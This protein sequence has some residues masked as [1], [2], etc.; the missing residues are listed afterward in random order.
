MAFEIQN[1]K[2]IPERGKEDLEYDFA[3]NIALL[4]F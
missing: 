4:Q 3:H 2:A 1:I